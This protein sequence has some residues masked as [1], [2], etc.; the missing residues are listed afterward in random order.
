MCS[1]DLLIFWGWVWGPVGMLFS[2]PMTVITKILLYNYEDT[3]WLAVL[4]GRARDVE[5]YEA[6]QQGQPDPDPSVP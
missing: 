6:M 4:L 2:V 3:R 1:S 5:R